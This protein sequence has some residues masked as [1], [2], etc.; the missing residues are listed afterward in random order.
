MYDAKHKQEPF[1]A[2]ELLSKAGEIC[3]KIC[4]NPKNES[5]ST[6][7]IRR[8]ISSRLVKLGYIEKE[9]MAAARMVV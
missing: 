5:L 6:L 4:D 7:E 2:I 9:V 3:E 1:G 8:Q